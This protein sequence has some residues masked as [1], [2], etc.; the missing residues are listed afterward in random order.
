MKFHEIPSNGSQDISEI[1]HCS[2]R[3]V[4]LIINQLHQTYTAC[5]ACI[6]SVSYE[7]SGNPLQWK[8]RYS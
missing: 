6:E 8:Q 7:F 3:E 1:E 4:P 5:S 2:P